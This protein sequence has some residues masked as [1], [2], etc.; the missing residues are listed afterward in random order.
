MRYKMRRFYLGREILPT[1]SGE[2]EARAIA[3]HYLTDLPDPETL[4]RKILTTQHALATRAA[5][6]G[7]SH[8]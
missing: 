4:R 1:P 2:L 3:S 8:G 5:I 7:P 6:K